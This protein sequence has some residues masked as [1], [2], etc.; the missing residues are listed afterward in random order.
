MRYYSGTG[1]LNTAIDKLGFEAHLPGGYAFCGPGTRLQERL[2][3]GDRPKNKLDAL[4]RQHDIFYNQ[5]HETTKRHTAD[6]IL[7][8]GALKRVTSKD[9]SLSER[10]ASLAVAGAMK[11]K[12][13]LGMGLRRPNY[14]QI[15][16]K[17]LKVMEKSKTMTENTLK[18]LQNGINS[19]RE[20]D[21]VQKK[22]QRPR[23]LPRKKVTSSKRKGTEK[24]N[25]DN[26]E[27]LNMSVEMNR[28]RKLEDIPID[29]YSLEK[30]SKRTLNNNRTRQIRTATRRKRPY[31]FN[32][33]SSQE[34]NLLLNEPMDLSMESLKRKKPDSDDD[35][36]DNEPN[37]KFSKT[38]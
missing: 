10:V 5:E 22:I 14:K 18:N 16:R 3:R 20:S 37:L 21:I 34:A 4:C 19:L 11:A 28:K 32:Q 26:I 13:K 17:C 23:P 27:D 36:S 12:V 38:E 24:I 33:H 29:E 30:K 8:D 6:K 1:F 31:K 9:A 7:A 15:I 2:A 25:N 35:D